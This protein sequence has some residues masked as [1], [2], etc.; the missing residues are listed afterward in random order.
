MS[1]P[2]PWSVAGGPDDRHDDGVRRVN[3]ALLTDPHLE[4][5]FPDRGG[6]YDALIRELDLVWDCPSDE[7]ANV[8]GFRCARCGAKRASGRR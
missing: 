5:L 3:H 8:V 6:E 7:A 2:P 4:A 1:L